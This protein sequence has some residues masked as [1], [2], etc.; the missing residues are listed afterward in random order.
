M[1]VFRKLKD[2]LFDIEEDD[3]PEITKKEEINPIKEIKIPKE[4][5]EPPKPVKKEPTF[6]F[7]LDDFDEKPVPSRV[8]KEYNWDKY[9]FGKDYDELSKYCNNRKR[10]LNRFTDNLT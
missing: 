1:G 2:V 9:K 8:K 4:E 5:P 10:G 7:P 3:I 6:N